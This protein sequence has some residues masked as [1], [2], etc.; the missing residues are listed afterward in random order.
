[1]GVGVIGLSVVAGLRALGSS[2]NIVVL[3]KY[4]HQAQLAREYGADM[5]LCLKE[6]QDSYQGLADIL[7]GELLKPIIGKCIVQGGVDIVFECV[8]SATSIDDTHRFT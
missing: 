1:M 3:A 5:V 2:A 8:G 4:P 7:G 6:E